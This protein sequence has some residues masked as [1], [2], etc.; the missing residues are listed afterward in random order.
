MF[1]SQ[2]AG[3]DIIAWLAKTEGPEAVDL[4]GGPYG[5]GV[6]Y[7]FEP[8]LEST[9]EW[10]EDNST[11]TFNT[12]RKLDTGDIR[13]DFVIPVNEAFVVAWSHGELSDQGDLK[14]HSS[15]YDLFE[16]KLSPGGRVIESQ[17]IDL[18]A[19]KGVP[20]LE[21]HGWW[22]WGAWFWI[23]YFLLFSKRYMK[24]PWELFHYLH[25]LTAY[26]ATGV[27][28]I[29]AYKAMA[30]MDGPSLSEPHNI[31]GWLTCV[32]TLFATL[33]GMVNTA[34]RRVGK[35]EEW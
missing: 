18:Q 20:E 21:T 23:G 9:F 7:D 5:G 16:L 25:A 12:K 22:M 32:L 29:M 33:T 15:N 19:E 8:N 34:M 28:F 27:T 1:G 31:A 10:S 13:E 3:S 4:V 6:D 26:F 17:D 30:H 14:Y 11:I 24:S 2:M 35:G